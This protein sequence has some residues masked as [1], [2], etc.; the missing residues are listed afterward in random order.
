MAYD[1]LRQQDAETF[2]KLQN[3]CISNIPQVKKR[4]STT[5]M[6]KVMFKHQP[7]NT[8]NMFVTVDHV[9]ERSTRRQNELTLYPPL[10]KLEIET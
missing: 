8:Q 9:H 2:Q 4:T 10:A 7:L 6:Y 3:T 1:C 5:E